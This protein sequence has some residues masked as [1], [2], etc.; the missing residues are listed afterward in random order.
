MR[1]QYFVVGGI[2][3]I[4][5]NALAAAEPLP[6]SAELGKSLAPFLAK[7]LPSIESLV[8]VAMPPPSPLMVVASLGDDAALPDQD[9]G[10]A[11][12]F[13]LNE[14]LFDADPKLDV[15]APWHY[16]YDTRMKGAPRGLNRDSAA[17]AYR[18]ASRVHADWCAHGRA[19]GAKPMLVDLVVDGCAAGKSS[20]SRRWACS[21]TPSGPESSRRCASS[22]SPAPEVNSRRRRLHRADARAQ[23]APTACRRSRVLAAPRRIGHGR[24][25]RRWLPPIPSLLPRRSN[26][27]GA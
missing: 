25:L 7:P 18:A 21:L 14:L 19:S 5:A 24:R 12:G 20:H 2:V 4:F 11:I 3:A 9:R 15:V 26:I 1:F 23:S 16:Q 10:F 8:G 27:F 22:P 13:T 6:S 17:N